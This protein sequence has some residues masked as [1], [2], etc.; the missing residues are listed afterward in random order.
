MQIVGLSID[1]PAAAFLPSIHPSIYFLPFPMLSPSIMQLSVYFSPH[2]LT[3]SPS[4]TSLQ[5]YPP[6]KVCVYMHVCAYLSVQ[7]E[8]SVW[9]MVRGKDCLYYKLL[10]RDRQMTNSD[11]EWVCVSV[12]CVCTDI[13][14]F[15]LS[16]EVGLLKYLFPFLYL[17]L[18]P[19]CG[20][21]ATSVANITRQTFFVE[22]WLERWTCGG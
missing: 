16:H 17:S 8:I 5:L 13:F 12:W 19:I 10:L 21:R 20:L 7:E 11:S 15:S 6:V 1:L 18:C 14:V 9:P 22:L 2:F 3:Y 4:N